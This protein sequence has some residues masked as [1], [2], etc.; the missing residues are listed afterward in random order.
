MDSFDIGG[1]ISMITSTVGLIMDE[2]EKNREVMVIQKE[3][4]PIYR[5]ILI[6]IINILYEFD[7][8]ENY[9]I[10]S[11]HSLSFSIIK[12]INLDL[13]DINHDLNIIKDYETLPKKNKV[14]FCMSRIIEENRPSSI[15]NKIDT[16]FD[17]INVHLKNL[18]ELKNN[19]FGSAYRIKHPVLQ[20]IWLLSGSNDLNNSTID[21]NLFLDNTFNLYKIYSMNQSNKYLNIKNE[22]IKNENNGLIVDKKKECIDLMN[23]HKLGKEEEQKVNN[24]IELLFNRLNKNDDD[25]LSITELNNID[26]HYYQFDNIKDFLFSFNESVYIPNHKCI[27]IDTDYQG[28]YELSG[29]NCIDNNRNRLVYDGYGSDYSNKWLFDFDL[30]EITVDKEYKHIQ[31]FTEAKDQGWGGTGHV[32]VILRFESASGKSYSRFAFA[33]NRNAENIIDNMYD[34]KITQEEIDIYKKVGV[35]LVCPRWS[36]WKGRIESFKAKLYFR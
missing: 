27:D 22:N 30:P 25:T 34:F 4:L 21:K 7:K 11:H 35:Y 16:N 15:K 12:I 13:I 14:N 24:K 20:K 32:H 9:K 8:L 28:P 36:G 26:S 5:T 18:E 10:L 3:K 2:M 17:K 31:C 1:C 6:D 29:S 23:L 19:I 33:I